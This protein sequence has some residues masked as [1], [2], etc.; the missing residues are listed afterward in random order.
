MRVSR[1]AAE[2]LNPDKSIT[3]KQYRYIKV[4]C[5]DHLVRAESVARAIVDND[6]ADLNQL[7]AHQVIQYLE[8]VYR[9]GAGISYDLDLEIKLGRALTRVR[10]WDGVISAR[11]RVL[12]LLAMHRVATPG[13]LARYAYG[14]EGS[15]FG[16]IRERIA[17]LLE[18]LLIDG[19]IGC[20]KG[21]ELPL[22]GKGVVTD[23]YYLTERGSDEL[24]LIASQVNY[25]ARL[26]MPARSR[27][28]HELA[29]T[30]ARLDIQLKH[31]IEEYLPETKI[32]S[33]QEKERRKRRRS[34]GEQAESHHGLGCGD[35]QAWV[36]DVDSNQGRRIEV[37][38][39]IRARQTEII[40]KPRRIKVWY[41][42]TQHRCDLIELSRGEF[43]RLIPDVREP[44]NEAERYFLTKGETP[45]RV[46][47][48]DERVS[49]ILN[50]LERIGGVGTPEAI[51]TIA[52]M[53]TTT[54][55]EALALLAEK[56][57]IS[58]R[59]GFPISGK[60]VGRSLRLYKINDYEIHS[61]YEFARLLTASKLV[62]AGIV[63]HEYGFSLQPYYCD[64]TTGVMILASGPDGSEPVIAVVDDYSEEPACVAN[65][66]R[67]AHQQAVKGTLK[68]LE[69]LSDSVG[70]LAV[71]DNG[72]Q[73]AGYQDSFR[74]WLTKEQ[75]VVVTT[76]KGRATLLR[77]LSEFKVVNL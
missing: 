54:A 66:A 27:L 3:N 28:Q 59:D 14:V 2:D 62:S 67:A 75:V 18:G 6:L 65:W 71:D 76:D 33:D 19:V 60:Q 47:V 22:I 74:L 4:C 17:S 10:Q 49:K 16:G 36:V 69:T 15:M 34:N 77:A 13:Q 50:A 24:H 26:G 58:Y 12:A 25:H 23:V 73:R 53:K 42:A 9:E 32:R 38:V 31:H 29:V 51:A 55:S 46:T 64:S 41:A 40:E 37:E 39:T 7:E 70:L 43:A 35:F 30:E 72:Q 11:V 48:S 5:A 44:L 63:G 56:G 8:E 61:V 21:V 20:A 57:Q 45:Q 52:G 68:G 1:P